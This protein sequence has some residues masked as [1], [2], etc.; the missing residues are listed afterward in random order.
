MALDLNAVGAETKTHQLEYDWKTLALY[1]LG[2][3][4]K[5]EELDYLYEHRGP[6]VYPS[7]AVVPAYAVLTDLLALTK[8]PY[9]MV[10][11]GGQTVRMLRPLPRR[12]V[13]ETRGKITGMYDLKRLA[14]VVFETQSTVDGE[15]VFETEWEIIY[16]GEGGF[17]G[18]RRPKGT[19]HKVPAREPDWSRSEAI[20]PEQAL[21][22]RL[23][24]DTNPLHVDPKFAAAV[25]FEQGPILHGL[26]TFGYLC[27]AVA[28]ESCGGDAS[29]IKSLTAQFRKPV[30]PGEE[31]R[32]EGFAEDGKVV[33]QAFAGGRPEAVVGSCAAEITS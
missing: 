33:M 17:G 12:G 9:E 11:H 13:L 1:A 10:V 6:K 27:R 14:Q 21:L 8:G 3:G 15:L 5:R 22:Y 4:A 20:S 24:G 32:T 18:P 30:W 2:I 25:G 31:L 16:R 19:S 29:K 26:C 28:I 23:S 7:F